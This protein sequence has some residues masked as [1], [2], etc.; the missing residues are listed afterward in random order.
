MAKEAQANEPS[1]EV[2]REAFAIRCLREHAR[3]SKFADAA[4]AGE[5]QRV[6]NAFSAKSAAERGDEAFVAEKFLKA[7]DQ[8]PPAPELRTT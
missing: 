7:H 5:E 3:Q 4:R 6:R 2:I 8:S 1:A